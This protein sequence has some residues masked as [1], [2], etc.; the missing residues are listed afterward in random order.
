VTTAAERTVGQ[1]VDQDRKPRVRLHV[2][3]DHTPEE[4]E[5]LVA[6]VVAALAE[7]TGQ[8][9]V[10]VELVESEEAKVAGTVGH[11]MSQGARWG[12]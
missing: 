6:R 1:V 2:P 11:R 4:E 8:D 7:S 5:A 12:G 10:D 3:P 9:D